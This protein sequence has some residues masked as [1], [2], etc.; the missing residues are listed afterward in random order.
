MD[1]RAQPIEGEVED[2]ILHLLRLRRKVTFLEL[3]DSMGEYQW[4]HLFSAL[5][6]LQKQRQ[7]ELCSLPWDYEVQLVD[8]GAVRPENPGCRG[9]GGG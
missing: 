9:L 7:V 6:H 8:A 4:R 2:R 1:A 5:N 3:A